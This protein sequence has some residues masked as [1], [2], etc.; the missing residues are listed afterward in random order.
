MEGSCEQTTLQLPSAVPPRPTLM[1]SVCGFQVNAAHALAFQ[2]ER[3]GE[4]GEPVVLE[5]L[6][7]KD[8]RNSA[9]H[10]PRSGR[11]ERRG[12]RF[13]TAQQNAKGISSSRKIANCNNYLAGTKRRNFTGKT[14]CARIASPTPFFRHPSDTLR[15][16]TTSTSSGVWPPGTYHLRSSR[17]L[18][19]ARLLRS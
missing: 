13:S 8:V 7:L 17:V 19:L 1:L 4:H 12:P 10:V 5:P 15:S 16:Y 18:C 2:R 3:Q 14:L 6:A 9:N 11:E